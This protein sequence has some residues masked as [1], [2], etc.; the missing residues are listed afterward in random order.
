MKK[1]AIVK[2]FPKTLQYSNFDE[3]IFAQDS[4]QEEYLNIKNKLSLDTIVSFPDEKKNFLGAETIL[5][6]ENDMP[7][8]QNENIQESLYKCIKYHLH[9]AKKYHNDYERISAEI[10]FWNAIRNSDNDTKYHLYYL[11]GKNLHSLGKI[12]ESLDCWKEASEM[13][14][15]RNECLMKIVSYYRE[16]SQKILAWEFLQKA[17]DNLHKIP[18]NEKGIKEEDYNTRIYYEKSILSY[19]N[20]SDFNKGIRSSILFINHSSEANLISQTFNNL[21]FYL[22]PLL[23]QEAW[24]RIDLE[25]LPV[26]FN[27][28]SIS[29]DQN[30][31]GII[32]TV[33][34]FIL[35]NGAYRFA[36]GRTC[37][38]VNYIGTWNS[39]KRAFDNVSKMQEPNLIS[40]K[41]TIRGLEDVRISNDYICA[42]TRNYSNRRAN[43]FS[44]R[45]R[46]LVGKLS[47]PDS[48]E[49]CEPPQDT[50]CEKNWIPLPNGQYIYQWHPFTLGN[51]VNGQLKLDFNSQKST[52]RFF[53]QAR[54]S[55]CPTKIGNSYY[56]IVH[57]VK[58]NLGTQRLYYHCWVRLNEN[59]LLTGYSLPFRFLGQEKIEYCLGSVSF[60][61]KT[62]DIFVSVL[63]RQSWHAQISCEKV[64]NSIVFEN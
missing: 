33:D 7:F 36:D 4:Y 58:E 32:R 9:Q 37:N 43:E 23:E 55:S 35:P 61:E 3:I 25:N 38:T 20:D 28:S 53:S 59:F 46:M 52:P 2:N 49:I 60:D 34:Y 42:T 45:N 6:D 18:S 22:K 1:I 12:E 8:V 24:K 57:F 44:Y 21:T 51:V 17:E 10:L 54:G 5:F 39:E 30:R 11:R 14:P 56:C 64:I 26:N 27:C 41:D 47:N 19:Y 62:I 29:V 13:F 15:H 48:W 31:T 50:Y 63:D 40:N 16:K